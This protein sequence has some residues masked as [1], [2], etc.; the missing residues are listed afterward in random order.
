[1]GISIELWE[2]DYANLRSR[3]IEEGASNPDL[4]DI[5]LAECG[6]IAGDKYLLLRNECHY[7]YNPYI[8]LIGLLDII[9]P[10]L[11][12]PDKYGIRRG[13]YRVILEMKKD[14]NRS[15]IDKEEIRERLTKAPK[16]R[17]LSGSG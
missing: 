8:V 14:T 17:D 15:S 11:I 2:F 7:E 4:L 16:P 13:S 1:M 10:E 9:F 12:Q 3:L 5:I 6:L